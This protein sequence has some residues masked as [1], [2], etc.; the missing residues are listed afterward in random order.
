MNLVTTLAVLPLACFVALPWTQEGGLEKVESSP[1][2]D[3]FRKP[4]ADPH[5]DKDRWRERLTTPSLDD[6][7]QSFERIIADARQGG[8]ALEA[9]REWAEGGADPELAWTAR[10]V[11]WRVG[12]AMAYYMVARAKLTVADRVVAAWFC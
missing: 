2:L 10:M 4:V 9:L 3:A 8:A 1:Q 12:Q 5:F 11:Y 6:R 7:E